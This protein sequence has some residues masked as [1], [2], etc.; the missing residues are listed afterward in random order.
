MK[1]V[2]ILHG[3][4]GYAGIHWQKWLNDQ[5][6]ERGYKV[7][8]PSLPNPDHPDRKEW[9]KVV[10]ETLKEANLSELVI[11]GHSLGVVTAL[12]FIKDSRKQI[13]AL[14]SVSGF[15]KDYKSELNSYFITEKEIDL[16]K[17][18]KLVKKSFVIYS[19]DDPYVPQ[20]T[21]KDLA[22]KLE[23]KPIII[24]KGGNLNTSSGYTKFPLLLDLLEKKL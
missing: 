19:N 9:L 16:K 14:I 2:L 12:D 8:M 20:E 24:K 1:E 6:L 5:L 13:L 18:K 11:V 7:Y 17:I 23:V 10:K 22:T 21:L 3:I 15:G 4:Q